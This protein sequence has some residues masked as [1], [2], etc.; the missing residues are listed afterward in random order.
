M[1]IKKI[2]Y[3]SLSQIISHLVY[4]MA[5]DHGESLNHNDK[6]YFSNLWILEFNTKY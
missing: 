5:C 4:I 2:F 3:L 6:Y 1:L